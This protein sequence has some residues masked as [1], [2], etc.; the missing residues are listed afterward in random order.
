MAKLSSQTPAQIDAKLAELYFQVAK[1]RALHD[2]IQTELREKAEG[3]R[4]FSIRTE[5]DATG[6]FNALKDLIL[7]ANHF[8]QEYERRP[9][10][11]YWH[12]TNANGHIHRSQ[13]CTSC[14]PDTQY[15]W[16]TDLSGLTDVEVVEREAYN[17]CS[18]CMPIAP[19]EQRAA[20]ERYNAEQRE[21]RRAEKQAKKDE[22]AAKAL[23]RARK[24][25]L[26]VE[27]ALYQLTGHA[28]PKSA[29]TAFRTEWS[30]YGH[31]GRK[32]LY[33]ATM[34]MPQMVG[35]TLS[36]M[37]NHYS[38]TRGVYDMNEAVKTALTERG[39][40]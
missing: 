25:A 39:L 24:H 6:A 12:V 27:K 34:D 7:K 14:F 20:R 26:K 10:Q 21:A 11:R 17:A 33:D 23:D 38:G 40:I 2:R 3:R 1:A 5:Q 9:W 35:N 4:P 32:N 8:E 36:A 16:R 31:D 19:A 29:V 15:G 18:V 37:M 22:K 28:D 30:E 13:A